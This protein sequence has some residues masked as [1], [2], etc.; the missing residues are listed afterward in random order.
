MV[1]SESTLERDWLIL[2]DFDDSIERYEE[3]PVRINYYD[4]QGRRRFYYPDVIVFYKDGRQPLLC[5]VKYRDELKQKWKEMKPKIR[6]AR[7]YAR[8]HG[9]RFGILTEREIRTPFLVNV[10]LL[11]HH[12]RFEPS[13]DMQRMVIDRLRTMR[14]ATPSRLL[15]AIH[16]DPWQT[17]EIIPVL[18]YLV[19]T[20]Q[21]QADLTDP[22]TMHTPI[23]AALT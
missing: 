16:N 5:E 11:R 4:E 14:K 2:L 19:S 20:R 17:A 12:R 23:K 8:E 6:A 9:W 10:K 21:V 18:W 22:L 13:A 3:Q 7:A 15:R 1:A